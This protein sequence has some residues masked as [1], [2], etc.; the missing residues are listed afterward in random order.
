MAILQN[1][2]TIPPLTFTDIP[3]LVDVKGIPIIVD[4]ELSSYSFELT[5]ENHIKLKLCQLLVEELF[6][7]GMIEF[8]R[9]SF[10][11]MDTTK[12]RARIFI[13][14]KDTTQVLRLNK[15]IP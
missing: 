2:T 14:P 13:T 11:N 5:D 9:E 8:T 4:Y 10:P 12:F 3:A 15:V 7:K 1:H 6:C